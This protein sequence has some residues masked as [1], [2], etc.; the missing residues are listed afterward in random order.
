[1]NAN[2]YPGSI[3]KDVLSIRAIFNKPSARKRG[4]IHGRK[5]AIQMSAVRR[6]A[7]RKYGK[8]SAVRIVLDFYG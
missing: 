3:G 6:A 4:M 2:H 7:E 1:M 8:M 5:H